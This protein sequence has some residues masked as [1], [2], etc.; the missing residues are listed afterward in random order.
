MRSAASLC[1]RRPA[2]SR[3][4]PIRRPITDT[5]IINSNT[6]ND[7][8]FE[9][10]LGDPITQFSPVNFGPQLYV[11]GYYTYGESRSADLMNHQY[12]YAD[13]LSL[14]RGKHQI[15]VGFDV[16]NSSSGGFGQEF[17]AGY[18]DGRFQINPLYKT[19]PIATVL[20][21]NPSLAAAGSAGRE[22]RRSSAVSRS[23][24]ATRTI[25]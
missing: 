22:P 6:L 8:R 25:T 1:R 17:G 21:L 7:A 10:L 11:S 23:R 20:T 9:F 18:V 19:I 16:M 12:E 2:C 14:S 4:T 24:S 13:T 3:A 5:Q 15:K